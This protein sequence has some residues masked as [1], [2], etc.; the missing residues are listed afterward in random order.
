MTNK[1]TETMTT[2]TG[3][4]KQIAYAGSLRNTALSGHPAYPTDTVD[5]AIAQQEKDTSST[6]E[7]IAEMATD[8]HEKL[9][10]WKAAVSEYSGYAGTLIDFLDMCDWKLALRNTRIEARTWTKE[11][12]KLAAAT[13]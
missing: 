4:E 10:A 6:D 11:M 3:S 2:L 5:V 13:K 7:Y 12:S 1:E 8:T 9:V